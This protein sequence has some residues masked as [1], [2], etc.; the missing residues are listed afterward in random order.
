MA[1]AFV[2]LLMFAC[3]CAPDKLKKQKTIRKCFVSWK[4]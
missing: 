2:R 4:W 3:K 1:S